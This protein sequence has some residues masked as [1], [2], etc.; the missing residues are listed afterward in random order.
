MNRTFYPWSVPYRNR[1]GTAQLILPA[2]KNN[3]FFLGHFLQHFHLKFL[4]LFVSALFLVTSSAMGQGPCP[5][6]NCTSGDIR[7]TKVALINAD[8]TALPNFCTPGVDLQ[9]KL[10]VTFE[11]TSKT[12]YGFLVVANVLINGNS[13]GT[14]AHC[15]PG[16]FAKGLHTMDVNTLTNGKPIHLDGALLM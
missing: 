11:V 1:Y 10:R 15:N 3:L 8:G 16:T 2:R 14:I 7:I 13:I 9:V 4:S 6:S 12:R 5:T